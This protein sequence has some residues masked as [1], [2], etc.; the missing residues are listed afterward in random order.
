MKIKKN[1]MC[2]TGQSIYMLPKYEDRLNWLYENNTEDQHFLKTYIVN[3]L[4]AE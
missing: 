4:C 3:S 1:H 2:W